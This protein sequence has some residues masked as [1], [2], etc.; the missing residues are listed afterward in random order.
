M[1]RN[2]LRWFL[3]AAPVMWVGAL[4]VAAFI[5]SRVQVGMI[6]YGISAAIYEVGSLVCHQRPERSFHMWGAQ[7]PVCAR[8]TGHYLGAAIVALAGAA[9]GRPLLRGA[10]THARALLL[11]GAVP[12]ATTLLYEW[13]TG[14]MPGHWIRAAAGFPLGA[15]VMMVVLAAS[16]APSAVEIH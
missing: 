11:L 14:E 5:A 3:I 15:V 7:L 10:W 1:A 12:T 13:T 4:L 6:A 2:A 9:V 8:C 16:M